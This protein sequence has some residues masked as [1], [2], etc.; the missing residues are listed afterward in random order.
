MNKRLRYSEPMGQK[1]RRHIVSLLKKRSNHLLIC[2]LQMFACVVTSLREE[3]VYFLHS[4][5]G[6][7]ED[8]IR[9]LKTLFKLCFSKSK[10]LSMLYCVLGFSI[11]KIKI[12]R[13]KS[14]ILSFYLTSGSF[15]KHKA[16][17]GSQS[18]L[19][20]ANERINYDSCIHGVYERREC[21]LE[22]RPIWWLH[23]IWKGIF[24]G[25]EKHFPATHM[26]RYELLP[27]WSYAFGDYIITRFKHFKLV[28]R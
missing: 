11:K 16:S 10:P 4:I 7:I 17:M 28:C 9:H 20:T 13:P 8:S 6:A 3:V 19:M 1:C 22:C 5:S 21:R 23:S 24:D 26:W 2:W 27:F 12:A 25:K 14:V 18:A 15:S